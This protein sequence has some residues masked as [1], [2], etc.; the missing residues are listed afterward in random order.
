MTVMS[1]IPQP[2][3][4]QPPSWPAPV[5]ADAP[6]PLPE[7]RLPVAKL[8]LDGRLTAAVAAALSVDGAGG[9]RVTA[10]LPDRDP[11]ARAYGLSL[12]LDDGRALHGRVRL[13][14]AGAGEVVFEGLEPP[15]GAWPC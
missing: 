3:P 2:P 12:Q 9:W 10:R 1:D 6:R 15:S 11:F 13:V 5:A 8:W 14:A 4:P 7:A